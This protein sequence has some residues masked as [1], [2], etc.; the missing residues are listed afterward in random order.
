M[1]QRRD[2]PWLR[3]QVLEVRVPRKR[4]EHPRGGQHQSSFQQRSVHRAQRVIRN[5]DWISQGVALAH[6]GSECRTCRTACQ[7]CDTRT[8]GSI[9][10]LRSYIRTYAN[11]QGDDNWA[12]GSTGAL[13]RVFG[14]GDTPVGSRRSRREYLAQDSARGNGSACPHRCARWR[15]VDARRQ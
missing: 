11:Q 6:S 1:H 15:L 14:I 4:H 12:I 3:A 13:R 8:D 2:L 9:R 7:T 5:T 10:T